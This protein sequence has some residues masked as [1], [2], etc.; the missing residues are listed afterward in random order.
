M[1]SAPNVDLSD[2]QTA[3]ITYAAQMNCLGGYP[4]K[5]RRYALIIFPNSVFIIGGYDFD[6]K[7]KTRSQPLHDFIYDIVSIQ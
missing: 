6:A 2:E 5:R 3:E 4:Y 7:N 1:L